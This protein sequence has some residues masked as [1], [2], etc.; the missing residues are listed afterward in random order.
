MVVAIHIDDGISG[1]VRDRPEF[2]KWLEDVRTCQ[3][4]TLVAWHVD[5][6]TREGVNVAALILDAIEGKDS[7]TGKVIRTPARLVDTK[8]LDS[9]GDETSFRLQFVLQAEIA[10]AER[11]RM[12]DR[13]A[14]RHRRARAAGRWSGGVIPYGF[15][16]VKA[17]DDKGYVLEHH[18]EEAR[19]VREAAD[20]ILC[21]ASWGAVTRWLNSPEGHPP[22]KAKA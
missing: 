19:V 11:E 1:A 6:L 16:P 2:M 13:S 15:R 20:R 12:R 7:V 22:H 21:G 3:V 14:A 18:P 17:E 10:R 5:R 9:D 8:G 4:D